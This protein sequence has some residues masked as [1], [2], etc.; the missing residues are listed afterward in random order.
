MR[1]AYW[2]LLAAIPVI[3][4]IG[5]SVAEMVGGYSGRCGL[6][7]ASWACSRSEYVRLELQSPFVLPWLMLC[8][9]SWLVLVAIGAILFRAFRSKARDGS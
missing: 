5:Y 8:S 4:F 9:V 6:L 3:T 2:L 1:R 7:D